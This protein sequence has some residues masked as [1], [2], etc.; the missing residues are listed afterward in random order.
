[1]SKFKR[2]KNIYAIAF[3]KNT[4][5]LSIGSLLA[6]IIG[7]LFLPILSRI[8]LPAQYGVYSSF[9]GI[10]QVFVLLSTFKY[11]KAMLIA[12]KSERNK[13]FVLVLMIVCV[14]SL[15]IFLVLS[16]LMLLN[17]KVVA[18]YSH[19]LLISLAMIGY[20]LISVI[21]NLFQKL[22]KF[23]LVA[24]ISITQ[25]I[26]NI[27]LSIALSDCTFNGLV[28]AWV[29]TPLM[30][31]CYYLFCKRNILFQ[32]I[33]NWN[34]WQVYVVFKKYIKFPTFYMPY[35]LLF[36]ALP[37]LIPTLL[38]SLFSNNEAGLYSMAYRVLM[39]PFIVISSSVSNVFVISAHKQ[40]DNSGKFNVIYL[41]VFKKVLL[42]GFV[43][44]FLAFTLGGWIITFIL[45][46]KWSGIDF[47]IKIL[48]IWLFFEFITVV[49]K[50]NTYIIAQKQHVG[51]LLQ[52]LNTLVGVISLF[53]FYKHGIKVALF[54]FVT[55][56]S[57]FCLINLGVTYK[58]SKT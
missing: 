36:T 21:I 15:I 51:L 16:L 25:T 30:V 44:Y 33:T 1:M 8:Y 49:F 54:A 26:V 46:L 47:Y 37:F 32:F 34:I 4:L 22:E 52:V 58:I 10:A 42:I 28:I 19:L 41:N 14:M 17:I 39:V 18:N 45:G 35:D 24:A 48:S 56:M 9:V 6:Q 27:F 5:M 23:K 55:S 13:L 12:D 50:S 38:S 57:I 2:I 31:A 53:V 11:E 7:I 29:V 43:I 40:Y 3:I 20:G